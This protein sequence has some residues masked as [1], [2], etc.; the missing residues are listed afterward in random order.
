[1]RV[2]AKG[3]R[4]IEWAGKGTVPMPEEAIVAIQDVGHLGL[5]ARAKG[6]KDA[7]TEVG[8]KTENLA[9]GDNPTIAKSILESY[10]TTHPEVNVIFAVAS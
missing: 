8:A 6:M 3:E 5:E 10:L 9:I 7:L 2:L 1:M 4:L